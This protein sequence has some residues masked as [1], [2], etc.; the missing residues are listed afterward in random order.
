MEFV[1]SSRFTF[2]FVFFCGLAAFIPGARALDVVFLTPKG[3]SLLKTWTAEE[4]GQLSK[5]GKITGQNLIIEESTRSLDLNSRAEIDL[6]TIYGSGKIARIPRFMIWRDFIKLRWDPGR[7]A[8]SANATSASR[9]VVPKEVFNVSDI[10]KIELAKH[11]LIYPGTELRIR[12]NPAASRGEK[13][14]TQS[15]LACHSLPQA[16]AVGPAQLTE[17]NLNH[18]TEHHRSAGVDLDS[19]GIR[20]LIAYSQALASQQNDVQ[21]RK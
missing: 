9:L 13:L 19:R 3:P 12:T 6:V 5:R 1:M 8:I 7:K 18:F 14:F 11:S 20:G 2:I 4:L 17:N 21:L 10:Q 15:C 16:K